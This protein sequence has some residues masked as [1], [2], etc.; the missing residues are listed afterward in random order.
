VSSRSKLILITGASGFLGSELC[1]TFHARGYRVRALVRDVREARYLAPY[2]KGG[3]FRCALPGDID[4]GAFEG[5]IRALIHCAWAM[6]VRNMKSARMINVE[7]TRRLLD[8]A[9]NANVHRFLFVSTLSAHDGAESLYGRS[10]LQVESLL[11]KDRDLIVRPG[12]VLGAGGLFARM[13]SSLDRVS[14]VPLFYGGRQQMQFIHITDLCKAL[15]SA[16]EKDLAGKLDIAVNEPVG[17]RVFYRDLASGLGKNCR[18]VRLPGTLTYW[19]LRLL[20]NLHIS[21][22]V[23]SENL[24][25]LKHMRVSDTAS[26]LAELEVEPRDWRQCLGV[27][28]GSE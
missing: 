17:I 25:G 12:L 26:C 15:Q 7:G 23:S 24:L 19:L 1:K 20:E 10:K 11:E 4:A 27:L 21:L 28:A 2:A 8:L 22:P 6:P 13:R 9:R 16:V 3:V 5:D 18:F 14:L